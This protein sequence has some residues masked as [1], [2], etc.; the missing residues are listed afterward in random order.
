MIEDTYEVLD[1]NNTVLADNMRID[2]AM[3]FVRALFENWYNETGLELRI[4]KK[5]NIDCM[6]EPTLTNEEEINIPYL[7][8][9]VREDKNT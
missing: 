8:Q 7:K 5:E 6:C 1:D 3:I 2:V 9:L 4:R